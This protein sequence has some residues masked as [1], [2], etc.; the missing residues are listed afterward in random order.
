MRNILRTSA[1]L[2]LGMLGGLAAASDYIVARST[3]ASIVKGTALAAGAVVPAAVGAVVTLISAGGEVVILKGT[4]AGIKVPGIA[5]PG[6]SAASA[7]LAALVNR[8][9]PR[10]NFGAMRGNEKCRSLEELQ[11]LEA[12]LAVSE[13]EGC[14]R[15]AQTALDAYISKAEAAAA[16]TP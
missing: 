8:P 1:V 5:K 15:M 9:P 13:I 2:A 6:S 12:I 4:D 7:T 11:T 3:D 14:G 10:R 16:T